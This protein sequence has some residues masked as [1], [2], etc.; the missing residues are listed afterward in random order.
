MKNRTILTYVLQ[1][2][3]C[4]FMM[5]GICQDSFGA[6]TDQSQIINEIQ[7][8]II[9]LRKEFNLRMEKMEGD[10]QTIAE[11]IQSKFTTLLNEQ[12]T[13]N[14]SQPKLTEKVQNL[15]SVLNRYNNQID[16]LEQTLNAMETTMSKSLDTIEAQIVAVKRQGGVRRPS[17][18]STVPP[19]Q[20]K[21]ESEPDFAPGQ[22]FRTAYRFYIDGEYD[23]A[24]AGFY[25]FLEDY[26]NAQLAGAAQ[27]WIAE[28]LA[29]MEEYEVAIQEY[30][31][32]I[33]AYPTDDKIPDA[34]YGIGVAL[35]KLGRIDEAKSQLRYVI[36][37]FAG[38]VASQKAQNRLQEYQ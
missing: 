32:L 4:I 38:T 17:V 19:E 14:T 26:P 9:T 16:L 25:K 8:Q 1:Y 6:M 33:K 11:N 18:A 15:Q 28:A 10:H 27:Y 22:L 34:H 37:H 31:Q 23:I 30:N 13:L 21:P 12:Q 36:D 29:K 3:L 7:Q 5:L 20:S 2:G 35:A 24:I